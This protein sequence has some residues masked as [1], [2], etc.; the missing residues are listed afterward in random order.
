VPPELR[1]WRF[2]GALPQETIMAGPQ[3]NA[4]PEMTPRRT[5]GFVAM[6]VGMFMAILDIQIVSSSLTEIQA[7]LSAS[8]QEISWVQT[9]Y[10]IAEIIMIPLSGFLG[11]ALSTAICLPSRPAASPSP[12]SAAPVP[13]QLAK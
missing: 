13:R 5:L 11:R 6:A 4:L 12:R 9:A 2:L 3:P 1:S 8:A 7:G 10:L